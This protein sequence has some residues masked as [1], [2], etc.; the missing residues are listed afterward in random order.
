L[1]SKQIGFHNPK[2]L[3]ARKPQ[4]VRVNEEIRLRFDVA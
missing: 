4:R 2:F 3:E 1:R